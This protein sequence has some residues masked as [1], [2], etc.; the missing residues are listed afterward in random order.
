MDALDSVLKIEERLVTKA[1]LLNLPI[2]GTIELTP[3][4]NMNCNM[5][6][7]RLSKPEMQNIG[8]LKSVDEWLNIAK[9]MKQAGTLFVLITGGEPFLYKDFIT[10]YKGLKE[11]GMIIT[12]NTNATLLT[13]EIA[14]VL[15]NDKPR[16]VNVTLYGASNETYQ[17]L[18]HIEKGFDKTI[19]GIE[20]LLK[21]NIDI[22]LNGSIVPLNEH[23]IDEMIA[24]SNKYNLYLKMD[25]YMY[26]TCRERCRPFSQNARLDAKKAALRNVEIKKKQYSKEDFE[27]YKQYMLQN[28]T[29]ANKM[30]DSNLT[31]RAGKSSYWITWYGDMTPCIFM[32]QPGI[33]VFKHGFDTSWKYIVE[34]IKDIHMPQTCIACEKREVC[35]VCGASAL[36]ETGSFENSPTYMCDYISHILHYLKETEDHS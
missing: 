23:E 24:I 36:C 3:L 35:H 12:I 8:R 2:G 28:E 11:L 16:R 5:C 21:H 25:T 22:K 26:P 10:L 13:E 1:T 34:K 29:T 14:E 18:C 20:L 4:C 31:C 19:A 17:N 30:T 15:S 7:I 33:D 27:N 6:F 32:K 9:Q